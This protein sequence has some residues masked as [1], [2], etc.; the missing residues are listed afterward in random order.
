MTAMIDNLP[1]PNADHWDWQTQ[2]LCRGLESSVFFHPE[3]ERG[4]ARAQRERRAKQICQGCPVLAACRN[5]AL[6]VPEPY[7][8]WG[9]MG[10]SERNLAARRLTR[11]P[12]AG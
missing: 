9:G 7:G 1:G 10:E 6:A 8:I 11:R 4:R 2:G 5:H 3:G 12:L